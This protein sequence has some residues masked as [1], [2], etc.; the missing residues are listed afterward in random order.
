MCQFPVTR[1]Y[2]PSIQ[3]WAW[4]AWPENSPP[5]GP[6]HAVGPGLGW[7]LWSDSSNGPG[8]GWKNDDLLKARL[9]DFW[10]D[11]SG[12]GWK[13]HPDSRARPSLGRRIFS[14]AFSWPGPTQKMPRHISITPSVPFKYP[15]P[16]PALTNTLF[17]LQGHQHTLQS[18][19]LT[20]FLCTSCP[21]PKGLWKLHS[22][23]WTSQA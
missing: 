9:N 5:V 4:A 21:L 11:G 23:Q 14:Q 19:N 16:L 2:S 7:N 8:L 13:M 12:L 20:I 18:P 15:A 3:A 22:Y 6:K 1:I 10:P 17:F